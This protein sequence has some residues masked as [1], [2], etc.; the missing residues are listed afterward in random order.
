MHF[1]HSM[2]S[3]TYLAYTN[4]I[5]LLKPKMLLDIGKMLILGPV[6]VSCMSVWLGPDIWSNI[7]LEVPMKMFTDA[8][9][10]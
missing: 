3:G 6:I 9:N 2:E 1:C 7:I 10:I 8:M 5:S 4:Y